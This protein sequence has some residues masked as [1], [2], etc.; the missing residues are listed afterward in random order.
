MCAIGNDELLSEEL[1]MRALYQRSKG[2]NLFDLWL[3]LTNLSLEPEAIMS[4]FP[5]YRPEGLTQRAYEGNLRAKLRDPQ[6]RN[7]MKYLVRTGTL[8]YDVDEAVVL[9]MSKLV[10]LV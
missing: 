4:A 5:A 2:R 7:D 10:S 3:A 1:E 6:S 8:D 9:V